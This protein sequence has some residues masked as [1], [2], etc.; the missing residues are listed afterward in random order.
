MADC[1]VVN[2]TQAK[3]DVRKDLVELIGVPDVF[4]D[5]LGGLDRIGDN[6]RLIFCVPLPPGIGI[7]R[8]PRPM[9]WR[10]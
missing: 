9:W 6:Y 5:R 3:T 1:S 4:T 2:L 8:R 7:G 10:S